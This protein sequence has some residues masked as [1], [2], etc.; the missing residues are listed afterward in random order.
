MW[1]YNLLLVLLS[2]L[3]PN[4]ISHGKER[5]LADAFLEWVSERDFWA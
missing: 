4:L 5:T 1:V 2:D 3:V